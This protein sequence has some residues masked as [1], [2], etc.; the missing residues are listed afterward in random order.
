M[1]PERHSGHPDPSPADERAPTSVPQMRTKCSALN[2]RRRPRD[3]SGDLTNVHAAAQSK[4][5]HLRWGCN[6]E[7]TPPPFLMHIQAVTPL[8]LHI[9]T[10]RS[11]DCSSH[12]TVHHERA[13]FRCSFTRSL[14]LKTEDKHKCGQISLAWVSLNI[15]GRGRYAG[16]RVGEAQNPGPATHQR[17]DESNGAHKRINEAGDSVPNNQ[18]SMT[19][20]SRTCISRT[21]LR[22]QQPCQPRHCQRGGMPEDRPNRNICCAQCRLTITR[23]VYRWGLMRVACG[24][25]AQKSSSPCGQCGTTALAQSPGLCLLWHYQIAAISPVQLLRER[26]SPRTSR[27][28]HPFQDRR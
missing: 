21:L 4:S 6:K 7:P 12:H 3:E 14:R 13:T 27:C 26:H 10:F 20:P 22:H 2:R 28:G 16:I 5:C 8:H 9:N 24:A 15:Q 25:E 18:A 23:R 17:L 1:A 11:H 19:R